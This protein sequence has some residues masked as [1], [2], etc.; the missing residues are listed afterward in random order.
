[1][2][3]D[4][5]KSIDRHRN[6]VKAQKYHACHW[7]PYKREY[8]RNYTQEATEIEPGVVSPITLFDELCSIS[9]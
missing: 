4:Y 5:E 2:K 3:C 9:F 1:M 8:I 7:I 6:A